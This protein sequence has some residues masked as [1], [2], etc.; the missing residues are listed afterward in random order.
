MGPKVGDSVGERLGDNVGDAVGEKLGTRGHF[1][2]SHLQ[3]LLLHSGS[4]TSFSSISS[5]HPGA[6]CGFS[7]NSCATFKSDVQLRYRM[8][9]L[10]LICRGWRTGRIERGSHH[11]SRLEQRIIVRHFPFAFLI[12]TVRFTLTNSK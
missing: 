10:F 12:L 6:H 1:F 9:V 4:H 7:M 2:R 5:V 8:Y 11:F 3:R